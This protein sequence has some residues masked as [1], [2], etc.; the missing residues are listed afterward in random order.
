MKGKLLLLFALPLVACLAVQMF[1]HNRV[2]DVL[3][4][5][6]E[7]LGPVALVSYSAVTAGLDGRIGLRGVVIA[8]RALR[9]EI[10]IAE[11]SV[12]LPDLWYLMSLQQRLERQQ[13][14]EEL[15][16][17][18]SDLAFS[19]RGELARRWEASMFSENPTLRDQALTSCVGRSAL[20][21]Q[22]HLLDY[23]EIRANV[24]LGYRFDPD[25]GEVVVFGNGGHL[26]GFELSGE[27]AIVMRTLNAFNLMRATS[28]PK[29]VRASLEFSDAGYY[30]RVFQ[31][32]EA[33]RLS[34]PAV[35]TLLAK[36]LVA[37]FEGLPLRPNAPLVAAYSRF[38]SS[39]SR[40][41]VTAYPEQ[42]QNLLQL[43]AYEPAAVAGLLNVRTQVN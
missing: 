34:K 11:L 26:D 10:R 20:P 14:P 35:V 42:P 2:S 25:N 38:V 41:I 33:D 32:C 36:D 4:R 30:D 24:E 23:D 21:T 17:S 8:P 12:K 22:M 6:S 16:V 9:D 19:T 31:H 5:V 29:V 1:V 3:G 28:N 27:L 18:V 7:R 39:G 13:Y 15:S 37:S 40:L 43:S